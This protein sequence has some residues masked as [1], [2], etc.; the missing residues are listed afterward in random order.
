MNGISIECEACGENYDVQV[1][2]EGQEFT[3]FRIICCIF[4]GQQI[5]RRCKYV[6]RANKGKLRP[7]KHLKER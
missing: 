7:A 5:K 2:K 3:D 1:K 4:C 6:Q